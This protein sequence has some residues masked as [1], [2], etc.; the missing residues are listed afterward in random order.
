MSPDGR[1]LVYSSRDGS[2]VHRQLDRLVESLIP[3]TEGARYPEFSPDGTTLAFYRDRRLWRIPLAGGQAVQ[4]QEQNSDYV[5][6]LDWATDGHIYTTIYRSLVRVPEGGGPSEFLELPEDPAEPGRWIVGDA[7]TLRDDWKIEE[8]AVLYPSVLPDGETLLYTA[9]TEETGELEFGAGEVWTLSL[10]DGARRKVAVGYGQLV[11]TASGHLLACSPDGT[12]SAIP[13]DPQTNELT[14]PPT[15]VLQ[16]V[17]PYSNYY[18]GCHMAF[19]TSGTAAYLPLK[20]EARDHRLAWL[21]RQGRLEP[22]AE[23]VGQFWSPRLS[24]DGK[25]LAYQELRFDDNLPAENIWTIDLERQVRTR[26]TDLRRALFPVWSRDGETLFFSQPQPTGGWKN[27][28]VFSVPAV[29]GVEPARESRGI[30]QGVMDMSPDSRFLLIDTDLGGGEDLAFFPRG[31]PEEIKYLL[32][33]RVNRT[34]ARFSPDGRWVA[35]MQGQRDGWE[36]FV[37]AFPES[38]GTIQISRDGGVA[39]KWSPDG[40]AIFYLSGKTVYRVPVDTSGRFE[41]GAPEVFTEVTGLPE[42]TVFSLWDLAEDGRFVGLIR[43]TRVT[44][45]QQI[46]IALNFFDEL[47]RLAPHT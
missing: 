33:S 30:F 12:V 43:D 34:A 21:D 18:P 15:P 28:G 35:F 2:L 39:P 14:G 27:G 17:M 24:P 11:P 42:N 26:L 3:G 29:G 19:S 37:T 25:R 22:L 36:V 38:S 41:A 32:E 45:R 40:Q 23:F 7:E 44:D 10:A 8:S 5:G 1:H 6:G 4:L 13:F 31:R 16:G 9:F 46:D 20:F 47:E